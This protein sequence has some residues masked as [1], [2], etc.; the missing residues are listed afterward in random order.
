M[1]NDLVIGI[2]VGT[3][4][5]KVT[6]FT[7]TGDV[8]EHINTGYPTQ[9]PNPSEVE[10]NP[11]HWMAAITSAL[12]LLSDQTTS[13]CVRAI[14]L[15]SQVNTH[16]F[17][18]ASCTP[19]APALVWQDG[20]AAQ[21]AAA[22]DA[23]VNESQRLSWW[24]APLP[25]DASHVLARMRWMQCNRPELWHRTAHVLLPKDYCIHQLTG[26]IVSDPWSNIGLVDLHL[27]YINE[28]LNLI[29][30][31][32]ARLPF[33]ADITEI[34]GVIKT[35]LPFA[36]VPV[37]VG[38]MDAWAGVLGTGVTS[39]GS[40]LYLSGTSEILGITSSTVQPTPGVLVMPRKHQMTLHV[41]PT[42][43][44]GASQLWL[45]KLLDIAPADMATLAA[46]HNPTRPYPLFLPHLQGERAPLWDASARGVFIGLDATTD[47]CALAR[48]V[49]EGVACSARWLLDS[50]Q[51]SASTSLKNLRAGGG[52]FQSDIWNQIRADTLGVELCRVAVTDPG[53]LGA[54]GLGAVA[55]GLHATVQDAFRD[56]VHIDRHYQPD[57]SRA[58]WQAERM[59][60]YRKA[61][62]STRELSYRWLDAWH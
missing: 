34:A 50:L 16:V 5:V 47:R 62:A 7:L 21:Q 27:G 15:T 46:Q 48:A 35:G 25:I 44:G 55:V 53:T 51:L 12:Q 32:Q 52:G 10:Q 60:L 9:R 58:D 43:S 41:G 40:G 42:Q 57:L 2:D 14:G 36:G 11:A 29:P 3:T 61:Y 8:V 18:D 38:T 22:L 56:L 4:S 33:L 24:G 6:L 28:L 39:D 49:Y 17:V 31:A 23:Q 1:N 54:A 26:Q 30:G 45:C 37:A 13:G 59:A 19:L 20:R